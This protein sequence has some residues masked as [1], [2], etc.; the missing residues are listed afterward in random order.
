MEVRGIQNDLLNILSEL[1]I[2]STSVF[3]MAK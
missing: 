1:K 2:T 3:K